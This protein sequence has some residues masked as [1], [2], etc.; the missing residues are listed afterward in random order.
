[1]E[2]LERYEKYIKEHC[3]NCKNEKTDLCDIRICTKYIHTPN[4]IET[5]CAYYE[6]KK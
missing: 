2:N 3:V 4:V 6:R 5:K 1:M